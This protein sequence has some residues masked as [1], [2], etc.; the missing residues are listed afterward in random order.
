LKKNILQ[1]QPG[2]CRNPLKKKVIDWKGIN[3]IE[4]KN[5]IL[6]FD[7]S[8][9]Y[10]RISDKLDPF[11]RI[12][13]PSIGLIFP[14]E[15]G[16]CACGCKKNLTGRKRRWATKH[17]SDFAYGVYSILAGIRDVI[18][19]YLS[20]Y[21]GSKCAQCKRTEQEIWNQDIEPLPR[22]HHRKTI[23]VFSVDHKFPVM[24]GGASGWLS[25]YQLLCH[26]CHVAK[27]KID[28]M[29]MNPKK[30]PRNR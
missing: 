6:F 21:H 2:W 29:G 18:R 28:Y 27:T 9:M 26:E 12:G 4:V 7:P 16:I 11:Q 19:F 17:C 30:K 24:H 20:F 13:G 1:V 10:K 15:S 5:R 23:D 14:N 22:E 8:D 25:N 3:S